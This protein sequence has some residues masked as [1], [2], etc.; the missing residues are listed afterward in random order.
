[1]EGEHEQMA[2]AQIFCPE[3]K[4]RG[5]TTTFKNP[6][7]LGSHRRRLHGV[8][9]TS[10]STVAARTAAEG[11]KV[12]PRTLGRTPTE[13][14]RDAIFKA[15]EIGIT[16]GELSGIFPGRTENR[17]ELMNDGLAELIAQGLIIYRSVQR[18]PI[19]LPAKMY[20]KTE[21]APPEG[22]LPPHV[23]HG[24]KT[25]QK[26]REELKATI[27]QPVSQNATPND[28]EEEVSQNATHNDSEE[29]VS[30][31]ATQPAL[32]DDIAEPAPTKPKKLSDIEAKLVEYLSTAQT[33]TR[34]EISKRFMR[35]KDAAWT[36]MKKL[37]KRGIIVMSQVARVDGRG[38]G[39]ETYTLHREALAGITG[40][41]T[42]LPTSNP[43]NT[44]AAALTGVL[45]GLTGVNAGSQPLLNCSFCE[46]TAKSPGGLKKHIGVYH[47]SA[48]AS[49]TTDLT[50]GEHNG[51]ERN[52]N[53]NGYSKASRIISLTEE[54]LE[55]ERL[56]GWAAGEAAA[57]TRILAVAENLPAG[58]FTARV[59]EYFSARTLRKGM[60]S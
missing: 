37:E 38:R 41:S 1:M 16:R 56:V 57:H 27:P 44:H 60:G 54:E 4:E 15:G 18:S 42:S 33:R 40:V 7:G 28:S 8:T 36:A 9:G 59:A 52:G 43:P 31:N 24:A 20:F 53:G 50:H 10:V 21:L 45:T 6:A 19:G 46:F 55:L 30:Q 17:Q 12:I 47:P 49:Q 26:T 25:S 5:I 3:C 35:D 51:N 2:Q 22:E 58:Q 39:T 13:K 32:F 34:T 48:Q 29:E 23:T 11:R 14:I